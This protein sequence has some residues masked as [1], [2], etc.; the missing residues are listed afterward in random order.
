[1]IQLF[2]FVEDEATGATGPSEVGDVGA[3]VAAEARPSH[4]SRP[5]VY[6][7]MIAS[8]DGGT[9]LDG[10]SG[11]LG[12]P[13][14][15]QVFAAL[16]SSADVIIVGAS[17]VRQEGYRPPR[18]PDEVRRRRQAQGR[19]PDPRLAVVTRSLD[20]EP[21]LA[22]FDDP[23]NRPL[24][25]T[26]AA[27]PASRRADL[28][29]VAD[30]VEVGADDVDLDRALVDLWHDGARTVLSEGGPSLNGQLVAAELVDEWNLSLSPHL[31]G[32]DAR[33]AA[34]GPAPGGPPPAMRLARVW[35]DEHY[36]FCR[37]IRSSTTAD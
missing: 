34:V 8:A 18:R 33:R 3:A 31:L 29:P 24:I 14:D 5:W 2:P 21:D 22:L 23:A 17:T 12:G 30:I 15:K 37:W 19:R 9:A 10:L 1:M 4:P 20:L 35:T 25:I 27:A 26:V 16:R 28:E 11:G 7:N 13:A 36:L 6:T 32:G